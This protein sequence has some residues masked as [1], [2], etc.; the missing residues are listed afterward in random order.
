MVLAERATDCHSEVLRG[1]WPDPSE[2][3]GVTRRAS[4][5]ACYNSFLRERMQLW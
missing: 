5:L 3:L 1:I 2:Y 4:L